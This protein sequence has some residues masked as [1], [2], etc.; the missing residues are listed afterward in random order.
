MKKENP[1][2]EHF[3]IFLAKDIPSE[4]QQNFYAATYTKINLA[5]NSKLYT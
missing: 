5:K 4:Y 1:E 3:L 2:R